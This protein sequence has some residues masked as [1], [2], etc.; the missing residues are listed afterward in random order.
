MITILANK[1]APG[2]LDRYLAKTG[3]SAQLTDEPIPSDAPANLLQ[4]AD[5][6][7]GAHGRFDS[8]AREVSYQ[9]VAS[10]HRAALTLGVLG[11]CCLAL[12]ALLTRSRALH[13]KGHPPAG[14][15]VSHAQPVEVE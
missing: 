11:I 8:R 1:L 14:G 6:D 10:R 13:H 15:V 4:T 12:M 7:Y 5:G 3:Y 9:A 2:L